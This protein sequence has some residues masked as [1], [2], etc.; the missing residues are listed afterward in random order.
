MEVDPSR[1]TISEVADVAF[2]ADRGDSPGSYRDG[3]RDR[4]RHVERRDGAADEHE[5]GRPGAARHLRSV[6]RPPGEQLTRR[7]TS[8]LLSRAA[9]SGT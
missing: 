7:S 5:V 2:I 3:A 1:A 4:S 9:A 8:W 6:R